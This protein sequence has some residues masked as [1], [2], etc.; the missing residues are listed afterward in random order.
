MQLTIF[1]S[2]MAQNTLFNFQHIILE[3]CVQESHSTRIYI[4]SPLAKIFVKLER[5]RERERER[6]LVCGCCSLL[7]P[8]NL[9]K[10]PYAH[11]GKHWKLLRTHGS[12][13]THHPSE[14]SAVFFRRLR[15]FF[16][17]FFHFQVKNTH[18]HTHFSLYTYIS[19]FSFFAFAS[20]SLISQL[21][22]CAYT[23]FSFFFF[24]EQESK[25]KCRYI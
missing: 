11:V 8:K 1:T 23:L 19:A 21:F 15:F 6:I 2:Q 17:F 7:C 20:L 9:R 16:C 25:S 10:S 14:I 22:H 24:A 5:V 4:I 13:S 12:R 18:T 3:M